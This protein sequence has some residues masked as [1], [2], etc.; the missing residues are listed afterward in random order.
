MIAAISIW[1]ILSLPLAGLMG[2][3]KFAA[4]ALVLGFF[5]VHAM[6]SVAHPD[7][8]LA[9]AYLLIVSIVSCAIL[10]YRIATWWSPAVTSDGHPVMP[11]GQLFVGVVGGTVV[12]GVAWLLYMRKMRR[13][14]AGE[15]HLVN[16]I[17]AV[18]LIAALAP[19][20]F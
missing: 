1:L 2:A 19:A 4:I 5:L 16:A 13:N 3:L 8:S 7:V 10:A 11:I 9:P 17:G 14:R 15:R 6:V 20:F 12:A 18:V